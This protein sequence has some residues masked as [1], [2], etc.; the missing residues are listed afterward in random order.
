DGI[1]LLL[2]DVLEQIGRGVGL[3][4]PAEDPD[5]Q[6]GLVLTGAL[7]VRHRLD[8]VGHLTGTP[9]TTFA[10]CG[11]GAL[12]SAVATTLGGVVTATGVLRPTCGKGKPR[13]Q[14]GGRRR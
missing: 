7:R 4:P 10:A 2:Q 13:R 5:L 11:L 9:V 14:H 8:T 12:R 6:L 3:V 1:A